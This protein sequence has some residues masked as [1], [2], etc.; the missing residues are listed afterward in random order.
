MQVILDSDEA[1]SV[2]SQVIS[3]VLDQVDLQ[4]KAKPASGAGAATASMAPA[5]CQSSASL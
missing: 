1:W 4:K 3:Q 2:M 5:R